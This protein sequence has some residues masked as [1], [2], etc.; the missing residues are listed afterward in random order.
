M[1]VLLPG[2]VLSC[3]GLGDPDPALG[4]GVSQE[5][6][7]PPWRE[8]EGQISFSSL[9][10][11]CPA[12]APEE[13]SAEEGTTRPSRGQC[14]AGHVI[15]PAVLVS[16]ISFVP[17]HSVD[18]ELGGRFPQPCRQP[19][20]NVLSLPR[21]F[22]LPTRP[23]GPWSIFCCPSYG[24]TTWPGGPWSCGPCNPSSLGRDPPFAS[25]LFCLPCHRCLTSHQTPSWP[26]CDLLP[27]GPSTDS[28]AGG[29]SLWALP[30]TLS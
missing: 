6:K 14:D 17:S 19:G 24:L 15:P 3:P 5:W 16:S 7:A 10:L 8:G 21:P 2:P 28:P 18:G 13:T 25:H 1:S 20:M 30:H 26:A 29:L 23:L 27:P 9:S 4:Q 22:L 11:S 12:S